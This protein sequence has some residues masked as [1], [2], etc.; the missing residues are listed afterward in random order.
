MD[1]CVI[2]AGNDILYTVFPLDDGSVSRRVVILSG[3]VIVLIAVLIVYAVVDP[4]TSVW[5]PKCIFRM[6]TG[7]D[8][9]G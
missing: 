6:M 1:Y 3:A 9:P 4:A 5:M 7:Y 2:C 8:C